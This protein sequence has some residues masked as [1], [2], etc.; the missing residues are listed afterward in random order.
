MLFPELSSPKIFAHSFI[1]EIL[2]PY[3]HSPQK[4][5]ATVLVTRF[6]FFNSPHQKMLSTVLVIKFCSVKSPH[7]KLLP[8]VSFIR[9]CFLTFIHPK[10]IVHSCSLYT[11]CVSSTLLTK[12]FVHSFSH[13]ILFPE[14]SS[15]KLLPTVLVIRFCCLNSPHQN[16]C[17]QFQSLDFAS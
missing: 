16:F 10:K 2:L 17:P 9:Y 8:T 6:C 12:T 1:H 4:V 11:D 13:Q 3:F 14:L 15:P 7:Q 5:L